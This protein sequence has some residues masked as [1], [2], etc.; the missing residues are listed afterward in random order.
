MRGATDRRMITVF[1]C[2]MLA[3]AATP[4][5]CK[6]VTYGTGLKS[7]DV[8]LAAKEQQ[9]REE[10][11]FIDWLSGYASGA[12]AISNRVNNV[13][14]DSNLQGT[15]SWL[16]NYCRAHP[17]T[18]VAVAL[19]V[20]VMGAMLRAARP[21][22]EV[23]IYG[24]GFKSCSTYIGARRQQ[25]AD[26]AAFMDWLGGYVSAVNAFSLK[27]DNVLGSS[28]LTKATLWVDDY[29]QAHPAVRFAAAADARVISGDRD[30]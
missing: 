4:A 25:G 19:D 29:C 22:V 27:T 9:T 13:L 5:Q 30:R 17:Q 7:C 26:E 12:N 10:L 24:A 8:Y 23:I 14:G 21:T 15:V 2:V 16:G 18:P 28:E 6:V 11:T 3:G 20:L 1:L